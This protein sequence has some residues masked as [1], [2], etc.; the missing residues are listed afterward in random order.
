MFNV[1]F[2]FIW[3]DLGISQ[4][5]KTIPPSKCVLLTNMYCLFVGVLR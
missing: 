2:Y 4:K 3:S 1:K 5:N